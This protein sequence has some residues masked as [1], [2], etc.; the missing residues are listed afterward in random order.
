MK[1]QRAIVV[2]GG[3]AGLSAAF[4]LLDRGFAV[5]LIE[6]HGWLGGRAFTLPDRGAVTGCDNGPHVMIGGYARTRALLRRLGTEQH[7]LRGRSLALAVRDAAGRASR[8]ALPPGPT[9]IGFGFGLARFGGLAP[10][11]RLRAVR[12]LC[13]LLRRPGATASVEDWIVRH[14]QQGAPRDYLWDPMCRALMN[15]EASRVD[16][17]LFVATLHR[18]FGGAGRD[19]ALWLPTRPWGELIGE[20]A[21]TKLRA[22]GARLTKGLA[23]ERI[24]V[25]DGRAVAVAFRGGS[26]RRLLPGEQIVAAVPWH[27]LARALPGLDLPFA[28]LVGSPIVSVYFA[29]TS[30]ADLPQDALIALAGGSPFHFFA[31][32]PGS[33]TFALLSGGHSDLRAESAEGTIALARAQLARHFPELAELARR[34]PAR[35]VKEA[36]A[37]FVAAPGTAALRPAPGPLPQVRGLSVCG[38]W[39]AT[40]LP[41]TLEGAAE[42]GLLAASSLAAAVRAT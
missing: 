42:S 7:F 6:A 4:G 17:G 35:L 19:A 37:T 26:I 20:P 16:A 21:E 25:E 14:R 24:L 23:M 34:A 30:E 38:D 5:E 18:A 28:R 32:R 1:T 22:A 11:E 10:R 33:P 41:A 15:A 8:L 29:V 2:G 40:G 31:R 39:T 13:A 9:R 36:R 3:V 27:A 12:G